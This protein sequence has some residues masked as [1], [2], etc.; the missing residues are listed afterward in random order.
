M[1]GLCS[2]NDLNAAIEKA[3]GQPKQDAE[4]VTDIS[5]LP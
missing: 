4:Q 5:E 1:L 3:G 2:Q